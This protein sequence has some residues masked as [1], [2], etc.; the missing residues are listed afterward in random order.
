MIDQEYV[1][2]MNDWFKSMELTI[3]QDQ[4]YID[5][6]TKEIELHT[7]FLANYKAA[8]VHDTLR[9]NKAKEDFEKYL[10]DNNDL[11]QIGINKG[12]DRGNSNIS[13][14]RKG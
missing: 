7:G 12:A 13:P 1:K 10:E 8:L 14:D 11:I 5:F 3:E 6:H 9:Y 4:L 2:G